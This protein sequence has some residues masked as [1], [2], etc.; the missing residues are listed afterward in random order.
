MLRNFFPGEIGNEMFSN[1]HEKIRG[2]TLGYPSLPI[3]KMLP[4][5]KNFAKNQV[6][7]CFQPL[8]LNF[9]PLNGANLHSY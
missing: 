2:E 5:T 7:V 9:V 6:C 4:K 1:N 8:L 3:V